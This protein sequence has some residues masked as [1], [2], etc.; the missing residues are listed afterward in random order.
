MK[1]PWDAVAMFE[2]TIPRH[3]EITERNPL[4]DQTIVQTL[5][6]EF[7]GEVILPQDGAYEQARAVYVRKG[8]PAIVL[9]PASPADVASA[10]R[11]AVS[12]SLAISVRSGGHSV[13]GLST[14]NGGV[15][16][17][18]SSINGVDI[19]DRSKGIVRIGS[20]A[21]WK[22]VAVALQEHG[23]ALSSGDTA[24][25]GI[26]GLTLGGGIGW[27]VR[28]HGLT[29][30]H[31]I[32]AELVTA[33]GEMLR[34]SAEEYPELFWAIR[35]GGGNFG[36]VT[37]F[38]FAA[39]PVRQVYSGMII[40]SLENVQALLA[41][42]RDAMRAAPEELTVMFLLL[43]SMMGNPPAAIA[44][45]CYA[46]DEEQEA[47]KAI[48][49]LLRIGTVVQNMVTRKNY[50]EVLE[51][52][53]PPDGVN[54]VVQNGFVEHL[55]DDLL[56]ELARHYGKA[57]SPALQIR[58]LRGA[59]NRVPADATAFA[60]R[61]S[62][63]LLIPAIFLPLDASEADIHAAMTP[64]K[65]IAPF[66]CGGYVN[67]FSTSTEEEVAACYPKATYERLSKIKTTFDPGNIFRQNYNVKP[68]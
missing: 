39:H 64:W 13:A 17:D 55:T 51:E 38:E 54:V 63:A 47:M 5:Q 2:R 8:S 61:T 45:C 40:Y 68:M 46:G 29:I 44:W 53:H 22:Q 58:Y 7:T 31:M 3:C 10:I 19:L 67:F 30:D 52:A 60:H 15:V 24:S 27:M 14:S 28:K 48:D 65:A 25:V 26:G 49:P 6:R 18:L 1:E 37:H 41:G 20:G 42:W 43:P 23:L 56:A 12:N 11:F 33:S 57:A 50:S 34:V 16:I 32:A 9:R 35:G 66:C 36:V 4:M 62:E 59:I 21:T